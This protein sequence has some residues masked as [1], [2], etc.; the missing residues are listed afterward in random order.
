M[1]QAS[2]NPHQ[3]EELAAEAAGLIR[4]CTEGAALEALRLRYLGKR[5]E[6]TALLKGLKDVLPEDKPLIGKSLN[7][8]KRRIE[9]ALEQALGRIEQQREAAQRAAEVVDVTL[10]GRR[11][12]RGSLHPLTQVLDEIVSIFENMGFVWEDGPEVESDWYNFKALNFPDDHPARDEQQTLF[13]DAGEHYGDVLLRTHTSPVQ[14]RVMERQQPPVRM[15][16]PGWVYR[17]DAIDATH[18][19]MFSQ[20]EGLLV[21][22]D[23]TFGDLKG[24]LNEFVH[25][26]YGSQTKTRFRPAFFPF[27][28]PSAEV[29]ISCFACSG[30]GVLGGKTCRL[31]QGTGWKE[32]LG[33]G[34]VDPALYRNVGYDPDQYS[35]FAFGMGIERIAMFRYEVDDIKLFFEGDLRF[36]RQF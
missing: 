13:V 4:D 19:P 23:V 28:E 18:Y 22:R 21:D 25:R 3:I 15:V 17:Y 29:D 31:C 6:F 8:G 20:V 7:L 35:G 5:G 16:C 34:M 36:L 32:I 14:I 1:A 9:Q 30:S 12:R 26:F 2:F 11:P 27:T 33:C 10:P 24:V